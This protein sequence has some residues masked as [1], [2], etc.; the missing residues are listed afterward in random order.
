MIASSSNDTPNIFTIPKTKQQN[1]WKD[2][3]WKTI[4]CFRVSGLMFRALCSLLVL[5][6]VYTLF[7]KESQSTN[8]IQLNKTTSQPTQQKP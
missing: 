1:L 2:D 6:R 4:L 5:G 3:A 8:H 7:Y